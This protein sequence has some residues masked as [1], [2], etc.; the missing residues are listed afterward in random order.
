[1]EKEVV[2]MEKEVRISDYKKACS[3]IRDRLQITNEKLDS[4]ETELRSLRETHEAVE[5]ELRSLQ[6]TNEA[7]QKDLHDSQKRSQAFEIEV[8]ELERSKGW[9][10]SDITTLEAKCERLQFRVSDLSSQKGRFMDLAIELKGEVRRLEEKLLD[11]NRQ[12]EKDKEEILLI[13][14][15]ADGLKRKLEEGNNL[16]HLQQ[17]QAVPATSILPDST[18]QIAFDQP[19]FE[20]P[21]P[22]SPSISGHMSTSGA[23]PPYSKQTDLISDF[24][25]GAKRAFDQLKSKE[26][27]GWL[28]YPRS[29]KRKESADEPA[30]TG[31]AST[32]QIGA[33]KSEDGLVQKSK[34]KDAF[35]YLFKNKKKKSVAMSESPHPMSFNNTTIVPPQMSK[36]KK[37]AVDAS[38]PGLA[39]TKL[40]ATSISSFMNTPVY[41][42]FLQNKI[43]ATTIP[44][45]EYTK[46]ESNKSDP[47]ESNKLDANKS[48]ESN[49]HELA[50]GSD[51]SEDHL[52]IMFVPE[53]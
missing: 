53:E 5:K 27:S 6:E 7:I 14:Q 9:L 2:K 19:D 38:S 1:M 15:Q 39:K 42:S 13:K 22:L 33:D 51:G 43:K 48:N 21:P 40:V 34:L 11:A 4:T 29:K 3:R 8:K 30:S 49:E 25:H 18:S 35:K 41:P 31:G 45:K 32:S 44:K 50:D 16:K 52:N 12:R 47:N 28:D 17:P 36:G 23:L 24:T 46:N 26:S 10:E 37:K 20:G